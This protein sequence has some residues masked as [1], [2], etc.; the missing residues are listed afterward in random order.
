ME[1]GQRMAS[2]HLAAPDGTVASAGAAFEPL[3]RLLPG[4]RPLAALVRAAPRLV[5]GAY[6]LV[7]RNRSRLGPLVSHGARERAGT[8]IAER[9]R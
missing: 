2:W 4:G 3:F 6:R 8:L 7:A 5:E 1:P 9:S